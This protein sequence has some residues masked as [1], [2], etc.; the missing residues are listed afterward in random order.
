MWSYGL[1]SFVDEVTRAHYLLRLIVRKMQS[2]IPITAHQ[3]N[4]ILCA[5][6]QLSFDYQSVKSINVT[7]Y[8]SSVATN[9]SPVLEGI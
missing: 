1:I 2:N 7:T 9:R 3:S 5:S 6:V 8:G 4:T